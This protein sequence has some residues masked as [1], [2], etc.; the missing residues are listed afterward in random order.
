MTK[1]L[2]A[3]ALIVTGPICT[4]EMNPLDK[5]ILNI[6]KK[7]ET[8]SGYMFDAGIRVM[9]A[10]AGITGTGV[11][12]R[13]IMPQTV[14][15]YGGELTAQFLIKYGPYFFKTGLF[16]SGVGAVVAVFEPLQAGAATITDYYRTAEGFPEYLKLPSEHMKQFAEIN[17]ELEKLVFNFSETLNAI[18]E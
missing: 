3:L 12:L 4:A 13:S 18:Q 17:P 8:N 10:S 2:F 15:I 1:F 11:I 9:L 5:A 7:R 6:Q 14:S 16:L